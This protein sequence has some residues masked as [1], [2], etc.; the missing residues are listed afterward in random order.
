[1]CFI[2]IGVSSWPYVTSDEYYNAYLS[3]DKPILILTTKDDEISNEVAQWMK[4][5]V[6]G[7]KK[8]FLKHQQYDK[9]STYIQEDRAVDMAEKIKMFIEQIKP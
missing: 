6:P 2:K 3:L 8:E 5:F 7:V 9:G 1:M 4:E